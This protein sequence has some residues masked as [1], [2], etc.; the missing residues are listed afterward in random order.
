MKL[1][2]VRVA[3]SLTQQQFSDLTGISLGTIKN[4]E[5]GKFDVGLKVI[6]MV[7]AVERFEKYMMWLMKGKTNPG[8]GQIAPP[9]PPDGFE[10]SE[11]SQ[12]TTT[13]EAK[14]HR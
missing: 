13:P 2:A 11:E 5:V 14:S 4:Y 9:L 8:L 12:V 10:N 3:E 1:R 7:L 6:D